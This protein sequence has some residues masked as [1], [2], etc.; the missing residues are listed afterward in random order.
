MIFR[1]TEAQHRNEKKVNMYAGQTKVD[2][3]RGMHMVLAISDFVFKIK[4]IFLDTLI[5]TFF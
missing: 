4:L 5:Q 2:R 3:R 1:L